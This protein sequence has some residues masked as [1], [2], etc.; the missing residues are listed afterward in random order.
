MPSTTPDLWL[1]FVTG[2]ALL[3]FDWWRR[4]QGRIKRS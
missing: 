1:L 3:G 4:G 2:A